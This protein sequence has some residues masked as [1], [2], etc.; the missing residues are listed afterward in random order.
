MRHI[1]VLAMLFVLLLPLA[2]SITLKDLIDFF[3]FDFSS[4]EIDIISHSDLM[5][6][7]DGNGI[8]D[9]LIIELEADAEQNDYLV[10]VD[11]HD[12]QV[13]TNETNKTLSGMQKFNIT[14]PTEFL[15]ESRFNYT[16]KIFDSN[17]S[18]KF[19]EESIETNNYSIYEKGIS[20][21]N[22]S[23]RSVNSAIE[24][25][26]TLNSTR[27]GSYEV[28]AYLEYNDSKIS[29]RNENHSILPGLNNITL[30]FGNETIKN[31]HYI[32]NYSLSSVKYNGKLMKFSHT[33]QEY[34]YK[35]FAQT[36]FFSGFSDGDFDTDNNGLV[37][38]FAI[39]ASLEIK[40]NG[41]Y[42]IEME[43]HDL[44]DNFI[45][46]ANKNGTF[47][48][49]TNNAILEFNGTSVYSRKLDGP[50]I[51]K[52]IRLGKGNATVDSL[53]DA[54]T[55]KAYNY[56]DFEKPD[57]PDIRVK[58]SFSDGY[59]YGLNNLSA[60]I[61][62][63]NEGKANA[64]NIFIDIFNN[65]SFSRNESLMMLREGESRTYEMNLENASDL[66][67]DAIADFDNFAEESNESNNIANITVKINRK[68]VLMQPGNKT[69]NETDKILI[70]LSA[71]DMNGYLISYSINDSRFSQDENVFSWKTST[72]DAGNYTFK[73]NVSDSYL[74]DDAVFQITVLDMKEI[75]FD[76]DG[77]NDSLDRLIGMPEH[78]NTSTINTSLL[79]GNST[80]ISRLFEGVQKMEFKD[81]GASI[82]EFN[83][84]FSN[85]SINLSRII[86]DKQSGNGSGAVLFSMNISLPDNFRKTI[87]MDRLNVSQ[88][89]VCIKD[90]GIISLSEIT[91]GCNGGN[92]FK[93]ECDGTLQ[94]G[95]NC[96]YLNSTQKY[97][98]SG[99]RH[100]GIKQLD[101]EREETSNPSE[102][103]SSGGG[104]G[105]SLAQC[106]EQWS[107]GEWSEC[108][109]NMQARQCIDSNSCGTYKSRPI[110]SK[111]C[112]SEGIIASDAQSSVMF[113]PSG[114]SEETAENN[115]NDDISQKSIGP[116]I[117]GFAVAGSNADPKKGIMVVAEIIILGLLAY[118]NMPIRIFK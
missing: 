74:Y 118:F 19:T 73:V 16:I 39:N 108:D 65:D 115:E 46:K 55:T 14:F 71:S 82:V 45:G 31:A 7:K 84:N 25:N 8:N 76:D 6:D 101:F 18:L 28:I 79:I 34:D 66:E 53:I 117:T 60:N 17:Y 2:Y 70:N 44:L 20:I 69:F 61:T 88:N 107:C 54:Y 42:G 92:E 100:S 87:Y 10:V 15:T 26:L 22:V 106:T 43:L 85:S 62:I 52:S 95:Y 109:N 102:S 111:E 99:L 80:N 103:S 56:A 58:I 59:R 75:D 13:I 12:S 36:S 77:I 63:T 41:L 23:D 37:D 90:A 27:N 5:I 47:A 91:N 83:F 94:D 11:L 21:I 97:I 9:T 57:M 32:G 68:P 35:D 96:T 51:I 86:M 4:D 110:E 105:S 113:K 30:R 114:N 67:F 48:I 29:S 72:K 3:S 89:G 116:K 64:F 40:E 33:T 98:L 81:G 112:Q 1:L 49:G 78:I 24:L 93:I 104:G 50:F 38:Y